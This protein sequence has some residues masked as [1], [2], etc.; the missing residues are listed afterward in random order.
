M[1]G[2]D[3]LELS[4]SPLSGVRSSHLSYRPGELNRIGPYLKARAAQTGGAGRDRTGDLLNAN[5]ALSQLSYS[6]FRLPAI[7]PSTSSS[8]PF[9][10]AGRRRLIADSLFLNRG[11]LD[12]E[13]MSPAHGLSDKS[14]ELPS[15]DTERAH[16]L[17]RSGRSGLEWNGCSLLIP[18]VYTQPDRDFESSTHVLS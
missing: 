16:Y 10:G 13:T 15:G 3:R 1:V 18:P 4:T 9:P 17:H 8:K 11:Q 14:L 2:L 7:R 6:P 12:A 5:Q